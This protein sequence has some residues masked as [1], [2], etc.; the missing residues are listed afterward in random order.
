M[1]YAAVRQYESASSSVLVDEVSPQRLT[2]M[3]YDGALT[4]LATARG[5]MARGET[6]AK[7]RAMAGA[8]AIIEHLRACLDQQAGGSIA[9]NLD[10]LYDYS[11]RRL[12]HANATN[13]A[14]AVD[15]VL[16][17]LRPLA[18]AW[19]QIGHGR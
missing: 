13:D 11:L 3:L 4:R 8:I 18:E 2:G 10:A 1:S 7:L 6:T 14:P 19:D 5:A 16:D 9:R 17:L 12:V 15:E